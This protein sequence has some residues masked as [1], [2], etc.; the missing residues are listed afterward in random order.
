MLATCAPSS[1]GCRAWSHKVTGWVMIGYSPSV[2]DLRAELSPPHVAQREQCL[3]VPLAWVEGRTQWRIGGGQLLRAAPAALVCFC[4]LPPFHSRSIPPSLRRPSS[5]GFG[6]PLGPSGHTRVS[7]RASAAGGLLRARASISTTLARSLHSRP[8]QSARACCA[9]PP[10]AAA[11]PT[12]RP[13]ARPPPSAAAGA[14][15]HGRASQGSGHYT[16]GQ[17]FQERGSRVVSGSSA[18][19]QL[20]ASVRECGHD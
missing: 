19:L 15:M 20:G 13:R 14:D 3:P 6:F 4:G 18:G 11:S 10:A 2:D 9:L 8:R 5:E 17:G 1:Y 7:G 12:A 16:T